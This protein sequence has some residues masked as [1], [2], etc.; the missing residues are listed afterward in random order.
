MLY[1]FVYGTIFFILVFVVIITIKTINEALKFKKKE[2][3][4][5]FLKKKDCNIEK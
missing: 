2:R 3:K 1:Y 5:I 4:N